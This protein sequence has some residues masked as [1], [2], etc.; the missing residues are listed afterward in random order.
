MPLIMLKLS[1]YESAENYAAMESTLKQLQKDIPEASWVALSYARL[2]KKLDRDAEGLAILQQF[3]EANPSNNDVLFAY[4]E[5]LS[6]LAPEQMLA[7]LDKFIAL[8][9]DKAD[10]QFLKAQYLTDTGDIEQAKTVLKQLIPA[11]SKSADSLR[12]RNDLAVIAYQQ[13]DSE[14]AQT[15]VDEVL[16]ISSEDERALL[17][18][19]Q[20]L[21]DDQQVEKA[22]THLRIIL[23]NNPQSD[24]ALV[25]L[26]QAYAL[27]GDDELADDNFRQALTVNSGNT[28]AALSVADA[29]IKRDEIN[30]AEQV[31]LTALEKQP[32]Q[33]S[34]LQALAQVRLLK[35][36]WAGTAQLVE[37]LETR[38]PETGV[39]NYLDGRISE[40][41]GQYEVAVDQYKAALQKQPDLNHALQGLHNSYKQL[42]DKKALRDYLEDFSEKNPE[43]TTA[44][45]MMADIYA[46]EGDWQQAYD[47]VQAG[48]ASKPQWLPGYVKLADLHEQKKQ[49]S[50]AE[51]AYQ[52]GLSVN[53]DNLFLGMQLAAFYERQQLFTDA[54]STYEQVL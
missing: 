18:A 21:I 44:K 52:R 7:T 14:T 22:V 23:R 45:T 25:M 38:Y 19:S 46:E 11:D 42:D 5:W 16:L 13:D 32:E 39:T 54:K 30:R 6:V 2:L 49:Y 17:L 31:L 26:A 15:L 9:E 29:L 20:L 3:A 40:G 1:V 34:L 28:T 50:D 27:S 37:T 10:L 4:I 8:N 33:A 48:I 35:D 53:P 51:V 43:Q 47:L 24:Q 12:A 36:D 41:Q